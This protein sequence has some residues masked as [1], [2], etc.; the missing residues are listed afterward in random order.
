MSESSNH[1]MWMD[2]II[3]Q[4]DGCFA[5]QYFEETDDAKLKRTRAKEYCRLYLTNNVNLKS[6]FSQLFTRK[7]KFYE[8]LKLCGAHF[9]LTCDRRAKKFR[10]RFWGVNSWKKM[11]YSR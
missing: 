6:I 10:A 9:T 7:L 2:E 8:I 1:S 11:E 3:K 5:G 4:E